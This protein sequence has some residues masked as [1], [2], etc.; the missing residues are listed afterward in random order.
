MRTILV[1]MLLLLS[2]TNMAIA[3]YSFDEKVKEDSR[4][5]ILSNYSKSVQSAFARVG[6][7]TQYS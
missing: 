4:V 6:D 2:S 1:V 3:E 5:G 7:M